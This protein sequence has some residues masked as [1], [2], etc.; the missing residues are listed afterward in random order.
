MDKR[1]EKLTDQE[2]LLELQFRLSAKSRFVDIAVIVV[3]L[4]VIYVFA[5]LIYILPDS[6]Y[7][8]QEN[9]Y[10]KLF[11]EFDSESIIDGSFT[12]SIADYYADQ[13]PLRDFFVGIKGVVETAFLK[14]ENNGAAIGDN[15][16][17]VERKDYPNYEVFDK[18]LN[19]ISDFA[20]AMKKTGIPYYVA[21]A[22]RS[23]DV[24]SIYLSPFFPTERSD[25]IWNYAENMFSSNYY[26]KY[27]DLCE[28]LKAAVNTSYSEKND[29]QYYYRTDH[30]WT[31]EGAYLAYKNIMEVMGYE[32]LDESF[33][34]PELVSESFYGTT[35]SSAGLKWIEP[36]SI[37]Y[38]RYDGDD[39]DYTTTIADSGVSFCGFYDYS[40]LEKKDKY[41]SFIG[42]NHARVD[43]VKTLN[44]ESERK[45]LLIFKDSFAHSIV[46]FLAYHFDLV[47]IDLRYYKEKPINA[48]IDSGADM[49]LVLNSIGSITETDMYSMLNYGLSSYLSN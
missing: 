5:I 13:F 49:V 26:L 48:V 34:T 19:S 35:W 32:W 41:S 16:Y 25:K 3:F 2:K 30:H 4:A 47:L 39:T 10:L 31:A 14:G 46:P 22:G 36:D 37:Y 9:R 42:G 18:N 7:S 27:I 28:P 20:E 23:Q 8:E 17:I 43:V 15:G 11:P 24:N 29:S 45:K 12:E 1:P 38:Y 21:F 40:Y 33:F 44:A 6:E